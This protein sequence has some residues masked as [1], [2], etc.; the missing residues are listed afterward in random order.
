MIILYTS[1]ERAHY[2]DKKKN[3]RNSRIPAQSAIISTSQFFCSEN[4]DFSFEV[5]EERKERKSKMEEEEEE[6][7]NTVHCNPVI[8]YFAPGKSFIFILHPS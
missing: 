8:T 1:Y 7:R 3:L 4:V 6:V 5:G 2:D